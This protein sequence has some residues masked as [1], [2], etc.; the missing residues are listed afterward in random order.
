MADTSSARGGVGNQIFDEVER[1]V[2]GGMN[3]S[4]A[5]ND[6]SQ[7][8]GRESGTVAANYYRVARQRGA[9]LR[10]RRR[11]SEAPVRRTRGAGS[12][13]EVQAALA[14]A[15]AAL[16]ELARAVRAQEQEIGRLRAESQSVAEIRRLAKRLG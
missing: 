10:P 12:G 5:F 7:R 1:L 6:I 3:K 8:T 16:E 4:Q 15:T 2:A 14:K 11:R 13:T 9:E